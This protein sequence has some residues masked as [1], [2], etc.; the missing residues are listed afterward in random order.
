MRRPDSKDWS[1]A[2]VTLLCLHLLFRRECSGSWQPRVRGL[3]VTFVEL[4]GLTFALP[5]RALYEVPNTKQESFSLFH[6]QLHTP[7]LI[8]TVPRINFAILKFRIDGHRYDLP[9][10]S[11]LHHEVAYGL[12]NVWFETASVS[13]VLEQGKWSLQ[14]VCMY[15][16][17]RE[18][19][20]QA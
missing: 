18:V 12:R 9:V 4:L 7:F 5:T 17:T 13:S 15:V 1:E 10:A 3:N 11:A 8:P 19:S 14:S 20:A 16:H 6:G 2:Q